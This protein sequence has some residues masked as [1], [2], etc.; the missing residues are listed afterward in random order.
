MRYAL[1]AVILLICPGCEVFGEQFGG[2]A[3][4][5]TEAFETAVSNTRAV[6]SAVAGPLG[7]GPIVD[8]VIIGAGTLATA[9]FGKKAVQKAGQAVLNPAKPG[10]SGAS[11]TS[12]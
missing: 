7:F 1:G 6:A 3:D 4:P 11:P 12:P 2:W 9:I 5:G 10:A 8:Y